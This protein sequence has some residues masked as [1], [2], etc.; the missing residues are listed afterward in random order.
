M[1][2][3]V[4]PQRA[5]FCPPDS[6][7]LHAIHWT[8][9]FG[10]SASRSG[11]PDELDAPAGT[12]AS[13]SNETGEPLTRRLYDEIAAF[14]KIDRLVKPITA[15]PGSWNPRSWKGLANPMR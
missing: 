12:R 7:H 5:V 14:H 15:V 3:G 11:L 2:V 13:L 4:V 8:L 10:T 6:R 1:R 9:R